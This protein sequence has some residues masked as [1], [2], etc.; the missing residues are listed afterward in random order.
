[1]SFCDAQENAVYVSLVPQTVLTRIPASTPYVVQLIVANLYSVGSPGLTVNLQLAP[2]NT[3][4]SVAITA[5]PSPDAQLTGTGPWSVTTDPLP[6]KSVVEV[7]LQITLSGLGSF[8]LSA[9]VGSVTL[10]NG[11]SA[12]VKTDG[13]VTAPLPVVSRDFSTYSP[14]TRVICRVTLSAL[15]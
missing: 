13:S 11:A 3:V 2:L 6:P 5:S 4:Q 9:T 15:S 8:S 10:N 14:H 7:A 1:L 12:Q